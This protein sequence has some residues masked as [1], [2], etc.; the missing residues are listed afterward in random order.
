VNWA[1][2]DAD[3]VTALD[4]CTSLVPYRGNLTYRRL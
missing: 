3:A 2:I 1:V 4:L